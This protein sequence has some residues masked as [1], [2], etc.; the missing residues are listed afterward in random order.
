[1]KL[2]TKLLVMFLSVG[3]IPFAVISL[4]SL[5]KS[6]NALS[7]QA[8]NQLDALKGIKTGQIEQYFAERKGDLGVLVETVSTLRRE[9]FQKLEAIQKIKKAQLTDYLNTMKSQLHVVKDDTLASQAL[10]ELNDAFKESG[11][12]ADTEA[13]QKAAP[14]YDARMKDI[15]TDNGWYDL[16][17]I[18]TDGDIVY[19]VAREKDLGMTIPDSELRDQGIGKAFKKAQA[20]NADDIAMADFAPYS[21][22]GGVPASF[23]MAQVR[24]SKGALNGYLAFQVPLEKIN[25]I[26]LRRNGMG[27][28]GESYLVGQ[29]GLMRSDSFL[30]PEGHSVNAS[31][32]DNRKVDTEA[33]REALAGKENQKVILDYNGNPVLSCWDGI[34][35]GSGIRWAMMSEMDVAEAFSPVDGSGNEF[36]KKYVDMYGYY[37]LFLVNPDGYVFYTA[38][39][40]S[41]YQT[42]LLN[43]K[44]ASSNLGKLVRDVLTSK[45]FGLADFAPYAASN[46]EPC[47]FIAQPVTYN[48]NVDI[49]VALQLSLESINGIMQKRDGMG[50]TGETY[51]VGSDKLMRS[52]SFLDATNHSVKASFANPSRGQVDTVASTEALSGKTDQKI[53]MDYNG[54]PVLSSYAPVKVE[55]TTWALIAEI[56]EA[57]AFHAVNVMRWLVLIIAIIGISAIT[58]IAI[59]I[60]RSITKPINVVID[61]LHAGAEQVT[62]AS[63]QVSSASQSLAEGS[64]EQAAA[65]EETSSSLEEMASMTKQ[66]AEN[67]NQADNL[68]KDANQIVAK[69]NSSMNQ[70]TTS[71]TDIT[72]AS[73]ETSKIIKTIDEIAFQTNLLALNAAVEAARAGEAG[74]GF[75]VVADEVRNLA[76]RAAEAAKNTAN[77]IEGTVKKIKDGSLL[78]TSTN[79]AFSEVAE[80]AK[81]V[82]E[83]VGEIAAASK[84]Q[85]QGIEQVNK[86]VVDMDQVTQQNAANAEESASASEEMNAQ[87]EQMMVFVNEMLAIVGGNI[88]KNGPTQSRPPQKTLKPVTGRQ[89]K[90]AITFASKT[91]KNHEKTIP[92]E[93]NEFTDF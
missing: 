44:Y 22:S 5:N 3:I 2:G 4:I 46:N 31:F 81:K 37:D 45:Q 32:K 60:T 79:D 82:G 50:K 76:M 30:D 55:G 84:E 77:L 47:A 10:A 71:M 90:K 89:G 85:A 78:V 24:D 40:E 58:T 21:P 20:M 80:S 41:D 12:R 57:E 67:A 26:M 73:E 9:T 33:V 88:H 75:A 11:N 52:D 54:N 13:W 27:K 42:N 1:M 15:M 72:K 8:F 70:L 43:G 25:K 38:A 14:K 35:L 53:I 62:A 19:T 28:T 87:A 36:Y 34:D 64:S 6:G 49:V 61:G 91:R 51:L 92:L 56:D 16:F 48:G 7:Q 17:L 29:D 83:L 63:G 69:A 65:I 66:N 39:R 59:L 86:A 18:N 68:M 23:M 93:D 74:A